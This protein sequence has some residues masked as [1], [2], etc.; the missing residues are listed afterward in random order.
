MN[1][2][3]YVA[4]W[5]AVAVVQRTVPELCENIVLHSNIITVD[6]MLTV[7]GSDDSTRG[8]RCGLGQILER[9]RTDLVC[10]R[11]IR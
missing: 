7:D 6:G 11:N 2:A 10:D 9:P 3:C 1:I 5:V 4:G 8:R